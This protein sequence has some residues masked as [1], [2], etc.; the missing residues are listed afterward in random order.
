MSG[1]WKAL[2][3]GRVQHQSFYVKVSS[4]K[5][6]LWC[7]HHITPSPSSDASSNHYR[8]AISLFSPFDLHN[9]TS[10]LLRDKLDEVFF[11]EHL[12]AQRIKRQWSVSRSLFLLRCAVYARVLDGITTETAGP[13]GERRTRVWST[14]IF[15]NR[16]RTP[17]SG[18][19]AALASN[20]AASELNSE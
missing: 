9:H 11:I 16:D 18:Q 3:L 15:E 8:N 7:S 2:L 10:L 4:L 5:T 17:P 1:D 12:Y 20:E 19:G 13:N 14:P 6:A